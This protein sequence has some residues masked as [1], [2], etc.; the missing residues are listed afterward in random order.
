MMLARIALLAAL[1]AS[2][3]GCGDTP[4]ARAAE[5]R[6]VAA[7]RLQEFRRREA[8]ADANPSKGMPVAEW[9]MP[10][11]LRE[12]SGLA[13][14][15]RGTV[16]THDD[17]VG[18][19]SEIDPRTG[20]LKKSFSLAGLQKGDFEAITIA[21][22]DI[23]LMASNGKLFKFRE[24]DDGEQVP[25]SIYDTGLGKECEF[26]SLTY[27]PDSSRLL[28]ACKRILDKNEGKELRI[29]M[30]PLP[31][32]KPPVVSNTM[33]IPIDEVRQKNKWKNFRPS[34]MNID[35]FTGNYIIVASREKAYVVVT[36]EGDV[37][38]SEMLPGDHRQAEGIA[39]TKD[40]LLLVSD[41]ANVTPPKLTVYRWRP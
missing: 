26:E 33:A 22:Q 38:K 30:L 17:N 7:K 34:D 35:P 1:A 6:S 9:I 16:L 25:Y 21:G 15:T 40:S 41:E 39:I 29:Y 37:V 3:D 11:T 19:V 32:R 27:E 20:I 5:A 24:G 2:L 14:T 8:E 10:Y 28:M 13:L 12:I 31:L 4:Q 23:Y 36:P 18:R